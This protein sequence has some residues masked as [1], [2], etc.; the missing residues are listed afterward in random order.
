MTF[1][2]GDVVYHCG[3]GVRGTVQ[4]RNAAGGMFVAPH[5][6]VIRLYRD[7]SILIAPTAYLQAVVEG[8]PL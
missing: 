1:N 5:E 2:I 8:A 4:P 7:D 3:L 6:T